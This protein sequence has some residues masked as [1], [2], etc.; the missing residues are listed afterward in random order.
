VSS[1]EEIIGRLDA[2]IERRG[3]TIRL[4]RLT[5]GPDGEQIPFEVKFKANV[6]AAGPSDLV[7]PGANTIV[8]ISPTDLRRKR[9]P[10]L[11]PRRD[12]H[13]SI[14]GNPADI[15]RITPIKVDEEVVRVRVECRG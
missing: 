4:Q 15:V 13:L 5:T 11:M 2:A 10:G 3:Q 8:V 9:F 6:R 7:E 12:D 1:P 14:D